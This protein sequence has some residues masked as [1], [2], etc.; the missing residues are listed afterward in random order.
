MKST[1]I[2]RILSNDI[3]YVESNKYLLALLQVV[4]QHLA[5]LVLQPNAVIL[6]RSL[7]SRSAF[8]LLDKKTDVKPQLRPT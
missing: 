1:I 4:Q 5:V 6:L 3:K 2:V 8:G 7:A